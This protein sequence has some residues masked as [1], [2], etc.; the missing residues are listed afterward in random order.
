MIT[1]YTF[2]YYNIKSSKEVDIIPTI[3]NVGS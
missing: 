1:N 2:D 3:E